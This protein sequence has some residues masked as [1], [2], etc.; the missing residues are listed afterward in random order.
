VGVVE[1]IFVTAGGGQPMQRL[2]E[3]EARAGAGLAGDRYAEHTGYWSGVDECQVTLI[4]AESLDRITADTGVQVQDGQHRRNI[5]VRGVELRGL[6]GAEFTVGTARFA[7][8]RPRPPC[9]Y[10]ESITQPGMT[11][12]LAA[13]RGGICVRVVESGVVR[14]GDELVVGDVSRVAAWF[15]RLR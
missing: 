11:R 13:R 1:A 2:D 4:E 7:Y 14:V 15:D 10:I 6:A 5:V 3:V 12:A 8:D 9:R